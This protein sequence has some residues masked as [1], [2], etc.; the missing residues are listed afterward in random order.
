MVSEVGNP[1]YRTAVPDSS[2][3]TDEYTLSSQFSLVATHGLGR[4][5]NFVSLGLKCVSP[6]NGYNIGDTTYVPPCDLT[7]NTAPFFL[8]FN[9]NHIKIYMVYV[10]VIV[11]LSNPFAGA[12]G[13][14]TV[15]VTLDK[16]HLVV[17][18]EI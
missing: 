4:T 3:F 14:N 18:A 13:F 15:P 12:F 17:K 6:E 8:Y 5:P 2:F 11:D 16:W 1:N 7:G 9:N 10:P